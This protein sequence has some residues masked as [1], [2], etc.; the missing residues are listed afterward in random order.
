MS[1]DAILILRKY[2]E[3]IYATARMYTEI[4]PKRYSLQGQLNDLFPERMKLKVSIEN[5]S[6]KIVR[7][8]RKKNATSTGVSSN[9][10]ILTL[11]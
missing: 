1:I 9:D 4:Y 10:S 5:H 11:A 7:L 8:M 2:H 6:G 3:D